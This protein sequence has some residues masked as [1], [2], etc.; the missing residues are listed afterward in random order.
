MREAERVHSTL[1]GK[2]A[3]RVVASKTTAA[4]LPPDDPIYAAIEAHQRAHRGH[5]DA[6]R[7]EFAFEENTV[8]ER[9]MN[10]EQRGKFAILQNATAAAAHQLEKT[11]NALV[12]TKP[13][14]V[15]G[16][17]A[18]CRYTK[19]LLG[20]GSFRPSSGFRIRRRGNGHGRFLRYDRRRHR[21]HG[22][23][24][25]RGLRSRAHTAG[26]DL[27]PAALTRPAFLLALAGSEICCC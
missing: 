3:L 22:L 16:I 27:K 12:T 8:S 21:G 6:V 7:V 4:S 1:I 18:V 14:T 2:N 15:A 17:D 10:A 11:S 19:S 25:G 5:I 9:N 24:T 20:D 13:T 26:A 23:T